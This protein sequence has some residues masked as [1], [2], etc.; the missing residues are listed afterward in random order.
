[1]IK[2]D[3]KFEQIPHI[4]MEAL[5]PRH[6][7]VCGEI[8]M[9]KGRLI[10]PSCLIRLSP[11]KSPTCQKCGKEVQNDEIE[12][13]QDCIKHRR[14]FSKGM[15][16]FN[17]T[18]EAAR[19][20]AAIKYK[21]K[22]EYLDFYAEVAVSKLTQYESVRSW[23]FDALVPVPVHPARKRKRGFNQAEELAVRI[24]VKL[25]VPVYS[26][27][28]YRVRNTD[29]LKEMNPDERLR[30]LQ[31]AFQADED[32]IGETG[33]K[34]VLLVDDIYTTGSTAE[35]CTRAL[36]RAGIEKVY[37]FSVCIGQGR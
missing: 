12:Y 17:Y 18:G 6:C 9:P 35:A 19:S 8:V 33:V 10:C 26:E 3:I 20:M 22:R 25:M 7:P 1:M 2:K 32:I 11:V 13:C 34:S 36:L 4:L 30:N 23:H 5:Y 27:F 24:G 15:A 31:K 16:L 29:P 14:S 28:L 21:N 37:F